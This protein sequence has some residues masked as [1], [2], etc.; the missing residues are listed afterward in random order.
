MDPR[1]T[2]VLAATGQSIEREETVSAVDMAARA[3]ESAFADAPGLRDRVQRLTMVS[4]VFSPASARAGSELAEVLG[5]AEV[6]AEYTTAGGNIPQHLVNRAAVDIAAGTLDA[7]L[8]AGGEAT[9]SFR[10]GDPDADFM[11]ASRDIKGE[12]EEDDV[13]GPSMKG[14]LGPAEIGIRLFSP[15]H[16]YP[17]FENALAHA[18]GRSH[19]ETRA[20]LGPLMASFSEVAAAH[21]YAWFQEARSADEVAKVTDANRLIAEPYPKQMNAFPNVDQGAAV[22]VTSLAVARELGLEDR[23]VFVWSGAELRETAPVTRRDLSDAPAM[24]VAARACLDAAGIGRDDLAL[25]D[26]Y[27]CFPI[28]VEVGAAGL[29]VALDDPRRLTVTGGLPFFGGPGNNYS[30]HAI[31]TVAD[32]LRENGGHRLRRRERRPAV[33]ARHGGLRSHAAV[34][35]LPHGRHL[36]GPGPDRRRRAALRGRGRGRRRGRRLHDRL[37]PRRGGREGAGVRDP[38]RRAARRRARG[39][40][41]PFRAGRPP[42]HRHAH[43]RLR[44][45]AELSPGLSRWKIDTTPATIWILDRGGPMNSDDATLD[46]FRQD[47]RSWLDEVCPAN[48]RPGSATRPSADDRKAW[49]DA[50]AARGYT[51]PTW[52][53]EYGGGGLSKQEVKVLNEEVTRLGVFP[54]GVSFFGTAMLGPVLLEFGNEEQKQ[55]HLPKITNG[56]INWCQGYSEPGAGS[57]L[58][59]LQTRA[60][61]EG[62]HYIING[63]KIW[64]TGANHADWMFCLVRTDPDAPKHDGISFV[65][66]DLRQPGIT[67]S[68]IQLISGESDF[69]QVF[70][71]DAKAKK[72]NLV[73]PLNGGWTIA[74]RL[75]QHERQMLSGGMPGGAPAAAPKKKKAVPAPTSA[76]AESA[77]DYL[78]DEGGRLAEASLRDRIAQYELDSLCFGLTL[79]RSGEEAKAG[80]GPGPATSMFKY[81][82]SEMNKRR[83][84]IQMAVRGAAG[85]GWEGEGFTPNQLMETRGWLRS[86]GNSIEGGTSEV[87]KNVIAKRVLGLPD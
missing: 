6:A 15:T 3:A 49:L 7:T 45:S 80:Q 52:P 68:P 2:P 69:C 54:P 23:C 87:Q 61:L 64:T 63:S 36:G 22:V 74:K 71:E 21:P 18:E 32:R 55:D 65:L 81:Y 51:T 62:D 25:I 76:L 28:A 57:D 41:N 53:K 60:V 16:L 73:G 8:L 34:A 78:G 48:L 4:V 47:V 17:M 40:G 59:G 11:R 31:A 86:K 46:A 27:S 58:A 37:R 72:E 26:L 19:D 42:A 1:R 30:M 67:I 10:A 9:R 20:H 85:L 66:F 35:G 82:A 39:G 12:G 13:V 77:R 43:P 70:F 83:G 29:G 56:E 24:R 5:L 75:L 44:L 14:V 84:E 79:K 38:R 33:Q 50:F